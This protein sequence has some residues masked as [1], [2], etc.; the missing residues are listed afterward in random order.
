VTTEEPE[1]GRDGDGD[2]DAPTDARDPAAR[3]RAAGLRATGPRIEV[4]RM[5]DTDHAHLTAAEVA[6]RLGERGI[7]VARMSVYNVLSN[8]TRVGVLSAAEVGPGRTVYE[9]GHGWHHHFVCRDCGRVIDVPCVVG[10]KP[11]LDTDLPG[12]EIEEAAVLFRGRCAACAAQ[13]PH[14]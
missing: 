8:L 1:P 9:S 4:L 5:L 3:I 6:E 12:V 11:C 7:D 14:A 13:A 10:A 2:G